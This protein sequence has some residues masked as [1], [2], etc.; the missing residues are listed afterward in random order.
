MRDARE[1][2]SWELASVVAAASFN[3]NPFLKQHAKPADFN[4]YEQSNKKP[5]SLD[6]VIG[7]MHRDG[8]FNKK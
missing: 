7:Q 5:S 8:F 1:K 6:T 2:A 3:A 4:A